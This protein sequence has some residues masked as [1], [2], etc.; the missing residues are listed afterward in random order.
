[1]GASFQ[2]DELG[3]EAGSLPSLAGNQPGM[4][5]GLSDASLMNAFQNENQWSGLLN[6]KLPPSEQ[7]NFFPPPL[8]D[9]QQQPLAD[10]PAREHPAANPVIA[11]QPGWERS[12]TVQ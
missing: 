10:V 6:D 4:A 8:A 3:N 7:S 9:E 1:M 5:T 12:S 11:P 2:N